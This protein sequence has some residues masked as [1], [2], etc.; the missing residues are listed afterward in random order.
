MQEGKVSA[1]AGV[2]LLLPTYQLRPREEE[3]FSPAVAQQVAERVLVDELKGKVYD[4][5]SVTNWAVTIA[6]AV[7]QGV[8]GG[9]D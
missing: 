3:K 7:K 2:H 1:H 5:E 6:D 4:D 9:F 8:K